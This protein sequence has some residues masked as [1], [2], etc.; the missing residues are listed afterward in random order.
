[1]KKKR[2]RSP[3]GE[4]RH[5]VKRQRFDDEEVMMREQALREELEQQ[6]QQRLDDLHHELM[7]YVDHRLGVHHQSYIG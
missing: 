3:G 6:C 4:H 2:S 7:R 5:R 1:M